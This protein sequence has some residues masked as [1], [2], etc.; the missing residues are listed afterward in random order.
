LSDP[1]ERPGVRLLRAGARARAG[2]TATAIAEADELAA[3]PGAAADTLY[4]A[5]AVHA[6]AAA[7]ARG[8][9]AER[10]AARAVAMLRQAV[11]AG[12]AD[13]AHLRTDPDL[14][15]LRGRGDFKELAAGQDGK[16][17]PP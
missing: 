12:Y 5:A 1:C 10:Y 13:V 9:V 16:G 4:G 6:V 2:D 11:A 15:A 7:V 8:D 14:D 3:A 17:K